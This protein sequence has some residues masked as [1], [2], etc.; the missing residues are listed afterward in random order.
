MLTDIILFLP[1]YSLQL[2]TSGAYKIV[3]S[4][5]LKLGLLNRKLNVDFKSG[6]NLENPITNSPVE[7]RPLFHV[8]I[9]TLYNKKKSI[10]NMI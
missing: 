4:T 3:K 5:S 9:E 7:C 6:L 8:F 10:Y 1:K 2:E